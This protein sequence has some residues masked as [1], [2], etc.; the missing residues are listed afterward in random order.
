MNRFEREFKNRLGTDILVATF[1]SEADDY[2]GH[3]YS[4][5][6]LTARDI[7]SEVMNDH[8]FYG[9]RYPEC[10]T[11]EYMYF[12][13]GTVRKTRRERNW[14]Y[15]N[16]GTAPYENL[17]RTFRGLVRAAGEAMGDCCNL[18]TFAEYEKRIESKKRHELE[19]AAQVRAARWGV[20]ATDPEFLDKLLEETENRLGQ[21]RSYRE[22]MQ[23]DGLCIG[24]GVS[25]EQWYDE[26]NESQCDSDRASREADELLEYF[27]KYLPLTYARWAETRKEPAQ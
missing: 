10:E 25:S 5:S 16:Y 1:I 19:Q 6:R 15:S 14:V 4:H 22:G 12:R 7:L 27:E 17:P 8:S 18:E 3:E 24:Y 2:S 9:K 26:W 13:A 21:L 20:S 11:C 23:E